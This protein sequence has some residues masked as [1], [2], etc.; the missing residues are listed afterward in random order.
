MSFLLKKTLHG[1][2]VLF[3]ARVSFNGIKKGWNN[4]FGGIKHSHKGNALVAF[5]KYAH[6]LIEKERDKNRLRFRRA[7]SDF[8]EL[9]SIRVLFFI[10]MYFSAFP[11]SKARQ[12]VFMVQPQNVPSIAFR[13]IFYRVEFYRRS[14]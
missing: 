11:S 3:F 8:N 6:F 2:I 5:E 7:N 12:Y 4:R 1:L 9:Y 13:V 14:R 10:S